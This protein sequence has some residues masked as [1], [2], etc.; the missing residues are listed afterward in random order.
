M[1]A[2]PNFR[3]LRCQHERPTLT[4]WF[5]WF[6]VGT[7][8]DL[9]NKTAIRQPFE[10]RLNQSNTTGADR[11]LTPQLSIVSPELGVP[12]TFRIPGTFRTRTLSFVYLSGANRIAIQRW[13]RNSFQEKFTVFKSNGC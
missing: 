2:N 7:W 9:A 13:Y 12:G 11:S 6:C 1:V 5:S 10:F 4:Y 3:P 8:T